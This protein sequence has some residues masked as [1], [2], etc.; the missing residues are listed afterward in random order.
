M[1][2]GQDSIQTKTA[3]VINALQN[4]ALYN[5]PVDYFS[6]IETH[7]SWVLLTGTYAYKIKKPVNLGFLDFSSLDKRKFYCHEELRLNRRFAPDMYLDV[8]SIRGTAQSPCFDGSGEIIEY[9]VKMRE[10]SQSSLLS[11]IADEQHLQT[12]HIDSLAQAV[13]EFHQL[14]DVAGPNRQYSIVDSI[15]NWSRENFETLESTIPEAVLPEYY[16]SLKAWC[17]DISFERRSYLEQRLEE[18]F[19]RECH[20]DLHLGNIAFIDGKVTLFDGIEFNPQLRM[21]DTMSEIAFVVM[22]LCARGY[23]HYAWRFINHYVSASGDYVGVIILRYYVV[24]RALV[25][26]KIEALRV[27]SKMAHSDGQQGPFD[28]AIRYLDLAKRWTANTRSTIIV[29]HG[30]SGSGKSTVASQLAE[31]LGAIQIRSDVE[32]KRLFDLNPLEHSGSSLEEGIYTGDATLQTYAR[33]AGLTDSLVKAGIT[34]IVD[35][36]FLKRCYRN[37]FKRLARKNRVAYITCSCN[38]PI[39]ELRDR[40]NRRRGSN[41]DPS[42]ASIE[43]LEQQLLSQDPLSSKELNNAFTVDCSGSSLSQQQLDA[44]EQQIWAKNKSD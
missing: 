12:M 1:G 9:A 23:P 41:K 29:M 17:L 22:D 36:S 24:Y 26:A 19:I 30:L 4:A 5:H 2:K 33:L 6:L 27:S 8:V 44:I 31:L 38:A 3:S 10:F 37:Q 7:I 15:F 32:R 25:R 20:G 11:T 16:Q 39:S 40:I 18:G 21:I 35:A 14:T 28:D 34:V 43:V 13:S 42:E